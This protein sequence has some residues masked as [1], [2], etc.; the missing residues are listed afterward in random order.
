M[1]LLLLGAAPALGGAWNHP[2]GGPGRSC[3]RRRLEDPVGSLGAVGAG[4]SQKR[5]RVVQITDPEKTERRE[6]F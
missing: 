4:R 1:L 3:R 2:T 6:R 5:S